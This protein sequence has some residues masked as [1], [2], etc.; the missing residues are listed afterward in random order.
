MTNRFLL[1]RCRIALLA[2]SLALP[3]LCGS[4]AD[5][6]GAGA[7]FAAPLYQAWGSQYEHEHGVHL[8]YDAVGSGA[9]LDRIRAR[10]VDFGASDVPMSTDEL[11][12]QGL[13]QFPTGIGGVVPVINVTGIAPGEL[14]LTGA[15]LAN[16]FLGRIRRWN[17]D[18]IVALNPTIT[19]PSAH[20]TVV[21]RA[22][23]SGSSLLWTDYLAHVSPDWRRQVGASLSPR[24]PVG[25]AGQGN[26]GVASYVQRTRFAIG[27]VEYFFARQHNLS[28]VALRNH[29]GQ[30]VHAGR[31]SFRA[32]SQSV[33][34][35]M[36]QTM[37]Q[38][39]IDPD[40]EHSWPITGAT[41]VLIPARALYPE[42]SGATLSFFDWALHAGAATMDSFDYVSLPP[43]VLAQMPAIW[44]SVTDQS[45]RQVWP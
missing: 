26:G 18:A 17:D 40:G 1:T 32:A 19:L 43:E 11:S 27:Y 16:I 30:F 7:T 21:H 33:R 29:H 24:W 44:R 25:V 35:D 10:Q 13:L 20:I 15:V 37:E 8:D 14:H 38:L 42:R 23:A 28:D 3:P 34:W 9:G 6:H 39:P 4:A 5:I 31:D 22:E 36:T 45:G 2:L 12:Q 41:F